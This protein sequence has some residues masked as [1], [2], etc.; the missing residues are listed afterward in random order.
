[1]QYCYYSFYYLY[2]Y[3]IHYNDGYDKY[4]VLNDEHNYCITYAK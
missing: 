1:M 2:I 3:Y 4:K